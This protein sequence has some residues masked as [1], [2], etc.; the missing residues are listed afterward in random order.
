MNLRP[1]AF[2]VVTTT[3]II[4]AA[5]AG[6]HDDVTAGHPGETSFSNCLF[7]CLLF[8]L[9]KHSE[10]CLSAAVVDNHYNV[11]RQ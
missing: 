4:A 7:T 1:V 8:K 6:Q 5:A 11:I 2:L 10:R 3:A 9:E